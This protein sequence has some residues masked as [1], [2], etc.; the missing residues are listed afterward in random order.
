[1]KYYVLLMLLWLLMFGI[2][3]MSQPLLRK[4]LIGIYASEQKGVVV[5]DSILKES[6]AA[7]LQLQKSDTLLNFQG[8]SVKS[9]SEFHL[10]ANEIRENESVY[11]QYKRGQKT[12]YAKGKAKG[13]PYYQ[14][15]WAEVIYQSLPAIGCTLRSI[16][17]KPIHKTNTPGI[18]FIPGYNCSSIENYASHF[19]GKMIEGWVKEGYTVYTVEK[20]GMGDSRGCLPCVDVDLQTDISL[21]ETAYHD[22]SSLPFVNPHNLFIWGH[23]MG[24]IIAPLIVHEKPCKGIMVFGTV[25]RPWSEFLLEMHRVQKPL[26]DSL[27]YEDT[28]E[29]IRLIQKVYYEFFVLKKSPAAL[30]KNPAYTKMV[31]SELEYKEGKNEMW[32]RHWRFWQQLDSINLAKAWQSIDCNVLVFHGES[33][34][35]QCSALEPFLIVKAVNSNHPGKAKLITIPELDHLLMHSKDFTEAAKNMNHKEYLKGN[36]DTRLLNESIQWI[37]G[38]IKQN[39]FNK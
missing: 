2:D 33:D 19:N 4:A 7:I 26:L 23:S 32:G 34:F 30:H 6:T 21:F 35:I 28:E 14:T 39:T 11:I 36:F 37:H 1:M 3:G 12:S 20:S 10:I 38:L 9:S 25:F 29:F 24:G 31:E 18:F 22:F 16:I 27:S 5:I 13:K 8:K 17:Y 15:D